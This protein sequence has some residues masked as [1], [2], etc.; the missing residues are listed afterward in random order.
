[1]QD[2]NDKSEELKKQK[3]SAELRAARLW[4][5]IALVNAILATALTVAYV[6]YAAWRCW[7]ISKEKSLS[8]SKADVCCVSNPHVETENGVAL[9][10]RESSSKAID[11]AVSFTVTG[12]TVRVTSASDDMADV[13]DGDGDEAGVC[14][15]DAVERG[16]RF[17]GDARNVLRLE[18]INGAFGGPCGSVGTPSAECRYDAGKSRSDE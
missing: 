4:S 9:A 2:E 6:P 14:D 10:G 12:K 15:Q 11:R 18:T 13:R 3:V 16:V 7:T 17:G 8:R 5:K 1:M